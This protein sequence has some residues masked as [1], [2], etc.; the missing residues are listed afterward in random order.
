M[1]V[2]K[3]CH[4]HNK[5]SDYVYFIKI[6]KHSMQQLMSAK[7]NGTHHTIQNNKTYTPIQ[8]NRKPK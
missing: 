2:D 1:L 4:S 7:L 5:S 3:I 6:Y 8:K